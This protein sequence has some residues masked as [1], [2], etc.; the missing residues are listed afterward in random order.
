MRRHVLHNLK[1]PTAT[2]RVICTR[3]P[4][5]PSPK[6]S[7]SSPVRPYSLDLTWSL[8]THN[9]NMMPSRLLSLLL[10][11]SAGLYGQLTGLITLPVSLTGTGTLAYVH[12]MLPTSTGM[13]ENPTTIK[14]KALLL[15]K[16][17]F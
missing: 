3:Q 1:Q 12:R 11:Q 8:S 5:Q 2:S 10:T 6:P 4:H 13:M 15:Q 7:S 9:K 14:S 17:P 16:M